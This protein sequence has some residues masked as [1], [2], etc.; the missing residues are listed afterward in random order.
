MSFN[1]GDLVKSDGVFAGVGKLLSFELTTDMATIVF[2][3]S[4]INSQARPT[5]VKLSALK[6]VTLHDETNVYCINSDTDYW[7]R[8]RY[9]GKM[10][11]DRHLVIFK[12]GETS[13][14]PEIDIFVLNLLVEKTIDPFEYLEGRLTDFPYFL[15]NREPFVESYVE[16]RAA[17]KS[18]SSILSSSVEIV[19]HQIAV[20]R[21]VL[22]DTN[23]K[24]LLAD[25]VGLG[26][27]IEACLILREHV[28]HDGNDV[29]AL[30][31]VPASLKAQWLEELENRFYLGDLLGTKIL[32]CVHDQM[33]DLLSL[34]DPTLVIID[35]AHLITPW[36]IEEDLG[37]TSDF[38]I[39]AT[40]T[41]KAD[42]SLLLSGTPLNGNESNF[43]AMLHLITPDSYSLNEEGQNKFRKRV[44]EREVLGGMYQALVVDN[45][46]DTLTDIVDGIG[47]LFPEDDGLS[48]LIAAVRPLIDWIKPNEGQE[49]ERAILELREYVG[50][51]FR[52]H[53]RMLRNRRKD[54]AIALLFPGL[55]GHSISEWNVDDYSLSIDQMLDAFRE[56]LGSKA[57]ASGCINRENFLE[58]FELYLISPNLIA[59]RSE[60]QLAIG[61]LPSTKVEFLE[62]I[63]ICSKR[64]QLEKDNCLRGLLESWLDENERGKAIVF[65]GDRLVADMVFQKMY[66]IF[67]DVIERH[68]DFSTPGFSTSENIRVLILDERGED[69]LNL[70]GGKKLVVHYSIPLSFIR[71][72]QRNGRV[73]RYSASILASPI[74]SAVLVPSSDSLYKK[75]IQVL[76]SIGVF[77]DSVASLQ[78][79]LQEEIEKAWS[80]VIEKGPKALD[81]LI[82]ELEG[83]TGLV[84]RELQKVRVQEELDSMNTVVVQASSFADSLEEA[85]DNAEQS[86]EKILLWIV[87]ALN[88]EKVNVEPDGVYRFRYNRDDERG[89][90][91]L[92]DEKTF[93]EKC[94][95]GIDKV[96][97]KK[98]NVV[99]ALM[100]SERKVSAHGHQIYPMRYGQPFLDSIF[101]LSRSDTRGTC[102]AL[103]R[104]VN[105]NLSEP[106]VY[107]GCFWMVSGAESNC[108]AMEQRLA[109]ERFP[110]RTIKHWFN[111]NGKFEENE[112]IVNKL[113]ERPYRA[114][115][116]KQDEDV[117]YEDVAMREEHWNAMEEYLP[118]KEWPE[119]VG[120]I[121]GSAYSLVSRE[122]EQSLNE[123]ES[124]HYDLE[125]ITMV[126]VIG[127]PN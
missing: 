51:N 17:C 127:S 44:E 29:M 20:V 79:V 102:S 8:A 41:K 66:D 71:I 39:V 3:E 50:E 75:W 26:K 68:E 115:A 52:L 16:Q 59:E 92:V 126:V 34:S 82:G 21:R 9:S 11:G 7:R 121:K 69:G 110:P 5:S 83:S 61:G 105:L 125:S 90:D 10:L 89:G 96:Q 42:I 37:R 35:E 63:I 19:P 64:E 122:I 117:R 91:T 36:A 57:Q 58:W 65:C 119:L 56:E 6:R 81:S 15:Y 33:A 76:D 32:L 22:T 13:Q 120:Q 62:H 74:R 49:R 30:I 85:D 95:T 103:I 73:N 55:A 98:R 60:K 77:T 87:G 46:N 40:A 12:S 94:I 1:I 54:P 72:E 99:T 80:H 14:V 109:D 113:L 27:T 124:I 45:D 104:K 97:S 28:L 23:K 43:N 38:S 88:F 101:G 48:F 78:Y 18:I 25:E 100:S 112:Q 114:K 118:A 84:A 31:S 108:S 106:K 53:Q 123:N 67:G 70:H 93:V 111:S 107:F 47:K 4:P 86:S 116:L 2:F 24:Y